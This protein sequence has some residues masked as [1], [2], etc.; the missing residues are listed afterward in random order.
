MYLQER[1]LAATGV[2]L[3][4]PR[5]WRADICRLSYCSLAYTA[6]LTI[7]VINRMLMHEWRQYR[8]RQIRQALKE[9]REGE[10]EGEATSPV[11]DAEQGLAAE[12]AAE[13]EDGAAPREELKLTP[14]KPKQLLD[15]LSSGNQEVRDRLLA[16]HARQQLLPLDVEAAKP[17]PKHPRRA[18]ETREQLV[19]RLMDPVL[20][21]DEAATLLEVCPTTVRRYTNRGILKCYRTPG[22]QRRFQLSEIMSF[23]E[24]R[25]MVQ[26]E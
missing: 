2:R 12:T 3:R 1:P 11:E 4:P 8:D 15:R 20:S 17:P 21:L 25:Q 23:M 24:R 9:A 13:P 26:E 22:N 5:T 16:L 6:S 18:A 19:Q 10:F 14:E 7:E